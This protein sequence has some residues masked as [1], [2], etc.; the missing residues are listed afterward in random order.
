METQSLRQKKVAR[1]LERTLNEYFR[2]NAAL[3]SGL[4]ITVT[5]VLAAQDLKMARVYISIFGIS[6]D[7]EKAL[8][9]VSSHGKAIRGYVGH[10]LGKQLQFIPEL[11]F[12]LDDSLDKI[13]EI[14]RLL[15]K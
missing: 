5:E 13:A 9:L 15:A 10:Q 1:L 7:K 3:F 14:D 11:F 8:V 6:V 2:V 4:M 12:K